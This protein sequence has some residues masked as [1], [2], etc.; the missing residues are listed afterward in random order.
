MANFS[1]QICNK[2]LY[3]H[4]QEANNETASLTITNFS[5]VERVRLQ[6]QQKQLITTSSQQHNTEKY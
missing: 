2:I 3:L 5:V 4:E 6:Q 1:R